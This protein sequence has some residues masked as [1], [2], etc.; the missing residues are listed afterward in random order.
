MLIIICYGRFNGQIWD[1]GLS[2]GGEPQLKM[3]NMKFM[4]KIGEFK[5]KLFFLSETAG[6]SPV[7]KVYHQYFPVGFLH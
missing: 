1:S 6:K 5:E 2:R 7:G 3:K 4:G